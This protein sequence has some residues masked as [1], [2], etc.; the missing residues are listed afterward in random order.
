MVSTTNKHKRKGLS[1]KACIEGETCAE[2]QKRLKQFDK[3]EKATLQI[4]EKECKKCPNCNKNIQK[5]G[6]KT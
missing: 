6:G 5:N 1:A 4:I 3:D 2:Y